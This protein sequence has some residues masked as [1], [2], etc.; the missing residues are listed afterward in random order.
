MPLKIKKEGWWRAEGWKSIPQC[1]AINDIYN[2][3]LSHIL[4]AVNDAAFQFTAG[5]KA[6][7]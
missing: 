5:K 7:F 1:N 4:L 6:N 2:I 3:F